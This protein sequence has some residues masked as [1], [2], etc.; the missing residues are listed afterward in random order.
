MTVAK[1]LFLALS[2]VFILA[3]CSEKKEKKETVNPGLP[4]ITRPT[5]ATY[6][7]G[8]Q[9]CAKYHEITSKE[10]GIYVEVPM[11]YQNPEK[12]ATEIYAYTMATFDPTKPSV[13]SI[14]GGPG[15]NSHGYSE[16]FDP[17]YNLIYFDQRG[18][19]CSSPKTYSLYLDSSLYSTDNTVRDMDKIRQAYGIN[20]WSVFGISYGT[21]PA[22]IYASTFPDNVRSVVLEGTLGPYQQMHN[23]AFK[24]E[25]YNLVIA[26]FNEARLK[27]FETLLKDGGIESEIIWTLLNRALFIDIGFRR[28]KRDIESIILEDGSVDEVRVQEF[29]EHFASKDERPLQAPGNVDETVYLS[30]ACKN[31]QFPKIQGQQIVYSFKM[32]KFAVAKASERE[33]E[34]LC[35]DDVGVKQLQQKPYQLSDY[36]IV[37][38]IYYFQGSHDGATNTRGSIEHWKAVPK[39]LSYF[40]LA[41]KGGHTPNS[42]R[43]QKTGVQKDIF[44]LGI[45]AKPVTQADLDLVN[46]VIDPIER[47]KLYTNPHLQ[48]S[49]LEEEMSGIRIWSL[50]Q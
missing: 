6:M 38:P 4:K 34:R 25:K 14:D 26:D 48:F 5:K 43:M 15:G 37:K 22:T 35:K 27:T 10:F 44:K 36:P 9:F 3:A 46:A 47:W 32:Q 29:A 17:E 39:G 42:E 45:F 19:G 30:I 12:G 20:E 13:V 1:N 33:A 41:A 40:M 31:L 28:A 24:A 23:R 11:D 50:A 21:V 18:L 2:A 8:K 16:P 49:E 7:N